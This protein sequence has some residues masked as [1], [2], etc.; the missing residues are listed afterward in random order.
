MKAFRRAIGPSPSAESAPTP[1]FDDQSVP[2][3]GFEQASTEVLA[4]PGSVFA[5]QNERTGSLE[6]G[7]ENTTAQDAMEAK[8]QQL[9]YQVEL[10]EIAPAAA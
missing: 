10:K 3:S 8:L 4:I 9:G 1:Q 6:F 7:A 2:Q 5:D